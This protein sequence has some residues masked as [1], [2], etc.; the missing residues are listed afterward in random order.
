MECLS[1]QQHE[2]YFSSDHKPV[3]AVFDV[4]VPLSL[5]AQEPPALGSAEAPCQTVSAAQPSL[6][7]FSTETAGEDGEWVSPAP[8]FDARAALG[9]RGRGDDEG[10]AAAFDFKAKTDPPSV[11]PVYEAT[12]ESATRSV[13]AAA[14]ADQPIGNSTDLLSTA[15]PQ[16]DGKGETQDT[17]AKPPVPAVPES[18]ASLDELMTCILKSQEESLQTDSAD[19]MNFEM[20]PQGGERRERAKKDSQQQPLDLLSL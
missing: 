7:D 15:R 8:V 17:A 1:Y 12:A 9:Q 4:H 13:E 14:T 6:P 2:R 20:T 11:P 18:L 3:S 19:W 10:L 16:N 5:F